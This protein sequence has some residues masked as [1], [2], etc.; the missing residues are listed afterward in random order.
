[1]QKIRRHQPQ[2]RAAAWL[3]VALLAA[4]LAAALTPTRAHADHFVKKRA[5]DCSANFPCPK[6]I[7]PRVHFWIEVF[8]NWNAETAILHDPNRPQ[9]VYAIINTGRG[10]H[11]SMRKRVQKKRKQVAAELR[12]LADAIDAGKA[13]RRFTSR[14]KHLASMFAR[15]DAA[16]IRAAA[17]NIRCQSGVRDSFVGGLKRY[18]NYRA[19]VD[20]TLQQHGL[21]GEISYLPFVESSYNPIAYSKAGAAGMWQIMPRTARVLGLQL[22]AAIDERFDPEAATRAAAKYLT[23]AE[24]S[25]RE[26]AEQ[27]DPAISRAQL[28]PFIITSYN[29]GVSGMKRA[30]N[31]VGP[32][33]MKVLNRHKSPR[34]QTAVKNFYASFLAARHVAINAESY[35]GN[36]APV[37][38]THQTLVLPHSTSMARIKKVFNL[39]ESQLRKINPSL[40]RFVWRN[41]RLIP[42]GYRL[43]LPVRADNWKSQRIAFAKLPPEEILINDEPYI[44][45]RGDT[46]CGIARA[47]RVNCSELIRANRLGRSALIYPRQKLII[48]RQPISIAARAGAQGYRV[49]RGD[50]ACGIAKRFAINCRTLMR[51]NQLGKGTVIHPGQR[52]LIP[53]NVATLE[54]TA[55]NLYIVRRG[56]SICKIAQQFS[57]KCGALTALNNLTR[58]AIIHPG[59]KLQIP[60]LV[61]PD[62]SRTALELANIEDLKKSALRAHRAQIVDDGQRGNV[63]G[64]GDDDSNSDGDVTVT[65][66][67]DVDTVA[68]IDGVVGDNIVDAADTVTVTATVAADTTAIDSSAIV[69]SAN[70]VTANIEV[71]IET[72]LDTQQTAQ[73]LADD[74][75]I[76]AVQIDET[77]DA[78]GVE[79]ELGDA[80]RDL[81]ANLLDTLP[82]LGIEVSG[83]A[84]APVYAVHVEADET[85][86]HFADWLGIGEA[87]NLRK[88]NRLRY[89][90]PLAIGKRLLLP[91]NNANTVRRF[92][93]KRNEY[94]QV[95]S[96]SLKEHYDLVGVETYTVRKGDSPWSLSTRLGFPLW[97]LYR[98]NPELRDI[99]LHP[100]HLLTLP[101]LKARG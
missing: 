66:N 25:L 88:L 77:N 4:A 57:V 11:R 56:D 58:K 32:D 54:L 38:I 64:D 29:Y 71:D 82:E 81:L 60:G 3:C 94:H 80:R 51:L 13:S 63:D 16:S 69:D 41:W 100:G 21:P 9:R 22:D 2:A 37:N 15:G 44:V 59:Q 97:L 85:L 92:E 73:D 31:E 91:V 8:A 86:G 40:T 65:V 49:R 14:E 89:R 6:E 34:F 74:D 18:Q 52:L 42:K 62:T 78:G 95:L 12:A 79:I 96:E 23:R 17:K 7:R 35:F 36:I 30:I 53:G 55:D 99:A 26:V 45:Q 27:K 93:Q 33:F 47:L 46:A 101:K 39:R 68:T 67:D 98:L 24:I 70:T 1:M 84:G 76:G 50:T 72:D 20:S 90:Q 10:C 28:N 48:P 75:A 61:V 43:R 83:E 87:G 5:L 19:M